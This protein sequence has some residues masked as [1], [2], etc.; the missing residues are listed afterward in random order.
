MIKIEEDESHNEI[1]PE[2]SE[3][4]FQKVFI[5]LRKGR[6]YLIIYILELIFDAFYIIPSDLRY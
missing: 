2:N 6:Y 3:K 4:P 5:I 1:T